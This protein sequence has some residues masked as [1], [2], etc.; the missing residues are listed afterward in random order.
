MLKYRVLT[1]ALLVPLLVVS[2]FLLP[3][4]YFA[5]F[6]GGF[7]VLA[8]WEW[9]GL[10]NV[11]SPFAKFAYAGTAFLLGVV[12]FEL[13]VLIVPI[14]V[15]GVL[16]WIGASFRLFHKQQ[17][18]V[19]LGSKVK[20]LVSGLFVLVPAWCALYGLHQG[21]QGPT[22]VLIF[23]LIIWIADIIAFFVGQAWGKQKLA[24]LISPGKSVEGLL[25]GLAGVIVFASVVGIWYLHLS[26]WTLLL[27]LVLALISA[28]FS[29]CGDL[30]E[31]QI[32]RRAGVKDSGKTL[33][34]HGGV[35]DRIDSMSAASPV[36][37]IGVQTIPALLMPNTT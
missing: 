11:I 16:W 34:G 31:S 1:A 22:M 20:P 23:M 4:R 14:G 6:L 21:P 15:I 35:L 8:A 36:F 12:A 10:A 28:L 25:G 7:V 19:P 27:W 30:F 18:L 5:L 17:L 2:I 33:P 24:P 13:P 37:F 26:A 3:S 32:K 9:S 29:V